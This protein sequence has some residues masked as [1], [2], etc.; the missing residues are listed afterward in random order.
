MFN[1]N[2]HIHQQLIIVRVNKIRFNT[3]KTIT[4]FR[5]CYILSFIIAVEYV[6]FFEIIIFT[7]HVEKRVT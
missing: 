2:L 5:M 6:Y 1:K 3:W 4:L 7:G